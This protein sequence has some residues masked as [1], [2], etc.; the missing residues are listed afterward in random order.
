MTVRGREGGTGPVL[1][2]VTRAG[3]AGMASLSGGHGDTG[4]VSSEKWAGSC[5]FL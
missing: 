5:L 1:A 4:S 3:T 2:P